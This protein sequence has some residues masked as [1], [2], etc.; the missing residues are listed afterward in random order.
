MAESTLT[1]SLFEL[2]QEV[3]DFLGFG[4]DS[5]DWT[6][7]QEA[8][9]DSCINSGIRQF[10]FPPAIQGATKHEWSFL[11]PV[12]QLTTSA[13]TEDYDLP[14]DFGGIING[15][16]TFY[17]A[18]DT[19]THLVLVGEGAIRRMRQGVTVDSSYPSYAAVRPKAAT[20][21]TGQRF[22]IMLYPTPD[23]TYT[24]EYR[25]MALPGKLTEAKPYPLGGAMYSEVILEGC[26]AIAE[27][28]LDD[29]AGQHTNSFMALLAAAIER[30][31]AA[32]TPDFFGY[33][34]DS[35]SETTVRN[36]DLSV[37]TVNGILPD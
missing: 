35:S 13:D 32:N 18:S 30:D 20:G 36:R 2:R 6:A 19:Y 16:L 11:R 27:Q 34:R 8:R 12:A 10:Y 25:Y 31:R 1:L 5:T 17:G 26:L 4:R 29:A 22:E 21:T 37:V 28:R 23:D 7:D 14:D 24:I 9:L 15:T 3:A 33:N